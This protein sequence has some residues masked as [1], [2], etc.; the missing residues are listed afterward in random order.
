[1]KP[2][3][4]IDL[5]LGWE[6]SHVANAG[7]SVNIATAYDGVGQDSTPKKAFLPS[8]Y[9]VLVSYLLSTLFHQGEETHS[10]TRF[11]SAFS[12]T[13]T[14]SLDM[15]DPACCTMKVN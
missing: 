7:G 5:D 11:F 13:A 8:G 3:S 6:L 4:S 10:D 14:Q 9:I 2:W 12:N 15:C 1:M